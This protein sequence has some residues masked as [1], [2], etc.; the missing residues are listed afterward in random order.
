MQPVALL[1]AYIRHSELVGVEEFDNM[2]FQKHKG[3]SDCGFR[4]PAEVLIY[5]LEQI[6]RNPASETL[7]M[8][9]EMLSPLIGSSL[10]VESKEQ[11]EEF[12]ARPDARDVVKSASFEEVFF[13]IKQVGLAD[14][15]DL[16]PLITS[17]QVRGF[18]DL[19]CWRKDTFVRKPFM[20]WIAAFIQSG[21][22]ETVRALSGIDEILIALFLKDVIH[23]Y[24]VDRDDPP[25]GTQLIFTPDNR[26]AVE[27]SEGGEATSIGMLILDALFKYYPA[28][29]SRI[30]TSVRYTT[31]TQL[32]ETAFDNKNRRLEAHGFVDYY[33]AMSIYAG[34]EPG[35]THVPADR[36][37]KAEVIPGE[38]SPGN[39][40]A[41]FVDSLLAAKFLIEAFAQITE[42][43]EANRVAEGLTALGNRILSANLVTLGELEGVR[44]ALE[45]MRDF[46]TIG[47]EYL[48]GQRADLS[49]DILRRSYVQTIF[50]IGFDQVARLREHA[51]QLARIPGFHLSMLEPADREFVD[52]LRRFK[53]LILEEGRYHNFQ[54]LADV[55]RIRAR[56]NA[57]K[58]MVEAFVATFGSIQDTLARTFNTATVQ[59]AIHG[60]FA[61]LPLQASELESWLAHGFG[62]PDISVPPAIQPFAERWRTELRQELEPLVGKRIDPRFVASVALVM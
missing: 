39:L 21:P 46:L 17:K 15:M 10:R 54:S 8:S 40:P 45:E 38:E 28:L 59:F 19:D 47:L 3:I 9:N 56:L 26:F 20:E 22:E 61:P 31:R 60:I 32:E 12:L 2:A 55:E 49:A 35:E 11:L 34:P 27:P 33:E 44:P 5:K 53:P 16:L 58:T 4:I 29:G 50:K 14:S 43:A 13:T 30:L 1:L 37:P 23:V 48:T 52:A 41:V 51:D 25:E 24:E 62:L 42:P 36:E 7:I 18:V 57:L 6:I